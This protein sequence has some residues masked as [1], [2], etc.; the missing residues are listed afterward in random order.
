MV[1]K[2]IPVMS[3]DGK[4]CL[5]ASKRFD[6]LGFLNNPSCFAFLPEVQA[7]PDLVCA[8]RSSDGKMAFVF[9]QFKL[10]ANLV[11]GER[12]AALRTVNPKKFYH[13]KASD[14]PLK[15]KE[16]YPAGVSAALS[17]KKVFQVVISYPYGPEPKDLKAGATVQWLSEDLLQNICG[18]ETMRFL[19][20]LKA[21]QKLDL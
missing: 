4:V 3:S 12:E 20:T 5:L 9:F 6:L 14:E 15:G 19:S 16:T 2:F 11:K 18:E 1:R 8:F 13:T 7:G 17:G 21:A 10:R